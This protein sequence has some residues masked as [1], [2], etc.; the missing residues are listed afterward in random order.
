MDTAAGKSRRHP[1]DIG[2]ALGRAGRPIRVPAGRPRAPA[3]RG[4]RHA[5]RRVAGGPDERLGAVTGRAGAPL[6]TRG[7]A[8]PG[9]LPGRRLAAPRG[10]M[11]APRVR[12]P[13][14][15]LRR[16]R[17]RAVRG[18][19]GARMDEGA[20][21]PGPRGLALPPPPRPHAAHRHLGGRPRPLATAAAVPR[22][23]QEGGRPLLRRARLRGAALRVGRGA[24]VPG[25]S[26]S[27]EEGWSG[28]R[29]G[30][31]CPAHAKWWRREVAR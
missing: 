11:P 1:E 29:F 6:S 21:A 7:L 14:R 18:A 17:R 19:A 9:W 27:A 16:P 8:R 15:P 2:R 22:P 12:R 13:P 30:W 28:T 31:R 5:H 10:G 20:P 25:R 24:L 4:R 26:G 23:R 3:P